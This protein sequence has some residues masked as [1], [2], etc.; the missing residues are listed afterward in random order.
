M[1]GKSLGLRKDS[2]H[3]SISRGCSVVERDQAMQHQGKG[4]VLVYAISR[5]S[6][7]VDFFY[8]EAQFLKML[9]IWQGIQCYH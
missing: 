6:Q 4:A 1:S 9:I 3:R 7:F 5:R 8:S 2:L